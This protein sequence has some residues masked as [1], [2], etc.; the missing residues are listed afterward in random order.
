MR[1]TAETGQSDQMDKA[2]KICLKA[3]LW[4]KNKTKQTEFELKEEV[5]RS[6]LYLLAGNL[7]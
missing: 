7:H 6:I 4:G 3:T 1:K 2:L 5:I